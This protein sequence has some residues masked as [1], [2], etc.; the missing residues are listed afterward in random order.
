[1]VL[2]VASRKS[3]SPEKEIKKEL[4]RVDRPLVAVA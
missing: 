3:R 2:K 4:D 1:M